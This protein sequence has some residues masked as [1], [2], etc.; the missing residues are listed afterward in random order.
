MCADGKRHAAAEHCKG[1][2]SL[3]GSRKTSPRS[4]RA[5]P[6]RKPRQ[7]LQ[8]TNSQPKWRR[9]LS[10]HRRGPDRRKT[11]DHQ[12]PSRNLSMGMQR[13]PRQTSIRIQRPRRRRLRP[14][15]HL[16][17][18]PQHNHGEMYYAPTRRTL[19]LYRNCVGLASV[20]QRDPRDV[21]TENLCL[22]CWDRMIIGTRHEDST[23]FLVVWEDY[24]PHVFPTCDD[25]RGWARQTPALPSASL[26]KR[27]LSGEPRPRGELHQPLGIG[28]G[29]EISCRKP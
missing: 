16:P 29:C 13:Q 4:R 11:C 24:T 21:I 3:T 27:W 5:S 14:G 8:L 23:H 26:R 28:G 12:L 1:G 7:Q 18:V 2:G 6:R 25:I 17:P 20:P 22:N 9:H 15:A 10:L 19:H